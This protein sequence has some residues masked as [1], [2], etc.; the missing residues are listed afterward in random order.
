MNDAN[1]CECSYSEEFGNR[2]GVDIVRKVCLDPSRVSH[3][4][5][6]IGQDYSWRAVLQVVQRLVW[7]YMQDDNVAHKRKVAPAAK[8]FDAHSCIEN[9]C[10]RDYSVRAA[11]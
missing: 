7:A 5:C 8:C 2:N 6:G 10:V 4:R 1:A 11:C 9:H 3:C